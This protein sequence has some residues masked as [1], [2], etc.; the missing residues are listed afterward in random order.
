MSD[1][2]VG[3][4]SGGKDRYMVGWNES[5]KNANAYKVG[6]GGSQVGQ[7]DNKKLGGGDQDPVV[8]SKSGFQYA[9]EVDP[10]Q[11]G[12]RSDNMNMGGSTQEG[13]RA[14]N[15]SGAGGEVEM[16]YTEKG[17]WSA[18]NDAMARRKAEADAAKRY[19]SNTGSQYDSPTP[20]QVTIKS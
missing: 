5:S 10:K 4:K 17:E 6:G 19:Y 15:G 2:M 20:T 16:S 9:G 7:A 13:I 14:N 1:Y 11:I 8:G 12:D 18:Q 3:R